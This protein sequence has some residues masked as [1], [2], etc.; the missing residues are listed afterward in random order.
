MLGPPYC[1][2]FCLRRLSLEAAAH[3]GLTGAYCKRDLSI[4]G[5]SVAPSLPLLLA[6]LPPLDEGELRADWGKTHAP[7]ESARVSERR[8]ECEAED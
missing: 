7:C 3:L 4:T 6:A 2:P 8:A 1:S 5:L